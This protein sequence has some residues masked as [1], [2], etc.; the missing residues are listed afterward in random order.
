MP[1]MFTYLLSFCLEARSCSPQCSGSCRC[2]CTWPWVVRTSRGGNKNSDCLMDRGG[3]SRPS[4][5]TVEYLDVAEAIGSKPYW[6]SA[7][8]DSDNLRYVSRS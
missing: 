8:A 5:P 4:G 1:A 7:A 2:H 6:K 3:D